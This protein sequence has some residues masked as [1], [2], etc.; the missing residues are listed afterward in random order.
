MDEREVRCSE[1][2]KIT[3]LCDPIKDHPLHSRGHRSLQLARC[4]MVE[5]WEMHC[6]WI[7]ATNSDSVYSCL[8]QLLHSALP[9]NQVSD[10]LRSHDVILHANSLRNAR[11]QNGNPSDFLYKRDVHQTLVDQMTTIL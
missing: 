5:S 2:C 6:Q 4:E 7:T 9:L 10:A 3:G 8:W 1:S 11:N